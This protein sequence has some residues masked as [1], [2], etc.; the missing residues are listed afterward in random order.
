MFKVKDQKSKL[1]RKVTYQKKKRHNV[2]MDCFSDLY[3]G[4]A[5]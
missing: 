1:Q 2:S 5:S 4:I 3:L